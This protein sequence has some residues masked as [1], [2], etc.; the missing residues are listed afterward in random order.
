[1]NLTVVAVLGAALFCATA[2][3]AAKPQPRPSTLIESYDTMDTLCGEVG[4][5]TTQAAACEQRDKLYPLIKAQGWCKGRVGQAPT[6][7]RWHACG[8]KSL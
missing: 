6:D 7:R 2:Q 3:A 1:M 8:P 4:S 5:P